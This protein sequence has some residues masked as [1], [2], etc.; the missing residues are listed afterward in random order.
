[1][2]EYLERIDAA[3][4]SS[5]ARRIALFIVSHNGDIGNEAISR[6]VGLSRTVV[7][8]HRRTLIMRGLV[9]LTP[10]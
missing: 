2:A 8:A 1:M 7:R 3:L 10:Q 4:L 6:A 5:S 9:P